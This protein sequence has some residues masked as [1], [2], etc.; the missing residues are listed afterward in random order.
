MRK[1]EITILARIDDT[2]YARLI[3]IHKEQEQA[4]VFNNAMVR[5]PLAVGYVVALREEYTEEPE[6]QKRV[7]TSR[8]KGVPKFLDWSLCE[9]ANEGPRGGKCICPRNCACRERMCTTFS[10]HVV[11]CGHCR[12][13]NSYSTG[14]PCDLGRELLKRESENLE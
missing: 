4:S 12:Q 13:F 5:K 6:K 7:A 14:S 9:H 3:K 1:V 2:D 11:G 10:E 8:N